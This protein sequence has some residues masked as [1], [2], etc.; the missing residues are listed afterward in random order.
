MVDLIVF[1]ER[2]GRF[3]VRPS[4]VTL[5]NLDSVEKILSYVQTKVPEEELS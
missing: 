2:E 4:E 5:E 3:K 1:L